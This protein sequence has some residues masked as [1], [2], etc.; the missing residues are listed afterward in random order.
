MLTVCHFPLLG[1]QRPLKSPCQ[2][3]DALQRWLVGL[4]RLGLGPLSRPS[5]VDLRGRGCEVYAAFDRK[6][7]IHVWVDET[8]PRNQGASLTAWEL[9]K[10]GVQHT[11]IA[12]NAGGHLMRQGLVDVVITGA[13]RVTRTGDACNKPLAL[14]GLKGL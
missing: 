6:V 2:G 7:P 8:R 5:T 1:L 14:V 9:A 4:C 12:D 13:D 11:V 3:A 10:H